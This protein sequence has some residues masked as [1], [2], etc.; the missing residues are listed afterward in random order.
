MT[1]RVIYFFILFSHN[2]N[3]C[4]CLPWKTLG[5]LSLGGVSWLS[6]ALAKMKRGADLLPVALYPLQPLFEVVEVGGGGGGAGGAVGVGLLLLEVLTGLLQL[7]Q[8]AVEHVCGGSHRWS[9]GAER[10][11]VFLRL[12]D[13]TKTFTTPLYIM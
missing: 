11:S 6:S 9:Q 5:W 13:N 7:G 10:R 4:T 8:F 1:D 12:Q 3:L 2:R